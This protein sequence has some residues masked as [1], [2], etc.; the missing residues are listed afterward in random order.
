MRIPDP[1]TQ[2]HEALAAATHRDLPDIEY[3]TRDWIEY[4]N[5]GK[6]VRIKKTRRPMAD[7][8][9]VT[10]FLEMWGSTAL[11][12]GGMGGSAMT[13]AYTVIVSMYNDYV[14]YFGCGRLAY[15]FNITEIEREQ[16]EWLM[17]CIAKRQMPSVYEFNQ[18]MN[19]QE[20]ENGI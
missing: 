11:G 8:V 18:K 13:N 9:M 4:R 5:T 7:E 17:D 6:D 3:E 16:R 15:K 2:L 20:N 10:M 19:I 14:V 12:Y 1:F